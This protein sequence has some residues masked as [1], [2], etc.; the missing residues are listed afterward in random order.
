MLRLLN[1]GFWIALA[2]LA[3]CVDVNGGAVELKWEIRKQEGTSASCGAMELARVGLVGT[4]VEGSSGEAFDFE[5]PCSDLQAATDFVVT[6][7]RYAIQIE[8]R[9]D[10]AGKIAVANT[11]SAIVRDVSNGNVV[12]LNTLLIEKKKIVG[13][14]TGVICQSPAPD[15]GPSN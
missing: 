4:P 15:A 12:E 8:A 1:A 3:G 2:G 6:P 9:C 13:D 11:P 7:G 14:V 5:W 10:G